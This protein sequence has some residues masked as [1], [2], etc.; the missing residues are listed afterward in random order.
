MGNVET[1]ALVDKLAKTLKVPE[2]EKLKNKLGVVDAK[3][4]VD[5]LPDKLAKKRTGP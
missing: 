4:L 5:R 1:K 3:A 2:T